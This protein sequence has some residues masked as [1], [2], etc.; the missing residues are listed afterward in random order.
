M[1]EGGYGRRSR[2]GGSRCGRWAD[3]LVG[4]GTEVPDKTVP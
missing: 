3:I 4:R 2:E 1:V